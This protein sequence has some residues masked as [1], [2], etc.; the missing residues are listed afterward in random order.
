MTRPCRP[1]AAAAMLV[2]G[3]SFASPAAS[4]EERDH[5]L[6][7]V[8]FATSCNET[9]QRRF[10]RGMRYQH[11][12]WYRQSKE[13]FEE[14]L[15]ADPQCSIAYWGIAQS[16][17]AN[18]F[19][20]T[21]LKNLQEALAAIQKAKQIGAKTQRENDLISAI[22]V[23]YADFD[24][25][26]QRTRAQSYL[27]AMEQVAIRHPH[28]DEVQ[29]YYALA[30]NIAAAP[31]DKTFANQLKAAAILEPL[32]KRRPQHPGVA[33]NLIHTYD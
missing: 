14:V 3:I 9:A 31:S 25:V 23:Y 1:T 6:G 19:N 10:N 22:E 5:Q 32:S 15:E 29:I 16:L 24:K 4:Q 20:P 33:H 17:L 7:A 2:F 28:D 13:I 11:S 8:H 27:K 12:F 21:P 26:N 30:L 18:P